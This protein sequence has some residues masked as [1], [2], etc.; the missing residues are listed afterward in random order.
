MVSTTKSLEL[1]HMDL[2]GPMRTMSR[3][4]K[5][6]EME[7]EDEALGLV[8]DFTEASALVKVAPKEGT[9]D[10]TDRIVTRNEARLVVQGYS[11]EEGIDYDE[12]FAPVARLE[13]IR[14]LIVFAAHMEFTLHHM[15]VKSAFLNGYL[16]EEVFV[17]QPPGLQEHGMNDCPN[18]CLNMATKEVKLTLPIPKKKSKPDIVFSVGLCA[19]FQAN[20]KESHLTTVSLWIGK[21]PQIKQQLV[22]FGIDVDCIPI[23]CDNTSAISMTK[24][25]V[26]HKKTKHID[27]RHHFLR[28]NY[29]KGLISIEFC[30]IDKQIVDIFTKSLSRENFER[31][32][33]ELGMIKIT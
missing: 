23:F 9:V 14:L 4:G 19:R 5:K 13:A 6:Y 30:A 8:K 1:V 15:D 20:P 22:D 33:L 18:F 16:K 17:K 26:H 28:D 7:H 31:N 3:G 29:D 10:G 11:Q 2:G 21:A 27:V 12:T 24:N 32:R 25:P